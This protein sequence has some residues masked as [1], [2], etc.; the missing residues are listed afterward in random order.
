MHENR[1]KEIESWF[2]KLQAQV[3]EVRYQLASDRF[4]PDSYRKS[5]Q[6][7]CD[8]FAPLQDDFLLAELCYRNL[9]ALREKQAWALDCAPN[10]IISEEK[11]CA[12]CVLFARKGAEDI[13]LDPAFEREL[14]RS[15]E[16]YFTEK[17]GL[18]QYHLA[19]SEQQKRSLNAHE[20][21]QMEKE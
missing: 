1:T 10:A 21:K 7:H 14:F 18:Q 17:P 11:L 20:Q 8:F 3:N 12:N 5:F 15:R 9:F 4:T 16:H 6:K 13:D 19:R 2:K